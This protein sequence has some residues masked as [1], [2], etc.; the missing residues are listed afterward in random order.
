MI[1]YFMVVKLS[2]NGGTCYIEIT[3]VYMKV[4]YGRV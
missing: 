3:D 4:E 2:R 1:H